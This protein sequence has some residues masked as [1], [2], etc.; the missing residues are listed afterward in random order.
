VSDIDNA[1]FQPVLT[2]WAARLTTPAPT[3]A[4]SP[5]NAGTQLRL[6]WNRA[7]PW[8]T[9]EYKT[10]LAAL[11]FPFGI[12]TNRLDFLTSLSPLPNASGYYRLRQS[13]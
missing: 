8:T 12:V 13:D 3:I 11:F 1:T 10:N 2:E 9:I 4:A 6:T 5:T 7:A